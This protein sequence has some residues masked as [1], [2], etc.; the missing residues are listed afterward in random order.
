MGPKR[1][2]GCGTRAGC[3][4]HGAALPL[5]KYPWEKPVEDIP[6]PSA[7]PSD[8]PPQHQKPG[9]LTFAVVLKLNLDRATH[10][11]LSCG[12]SAAGP[13]LAVLG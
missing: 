5:T 1:Q 10:P 2:L 8:A 3:A 11:A 7:P 13:S 9:D 6:V 12:S 4:Q